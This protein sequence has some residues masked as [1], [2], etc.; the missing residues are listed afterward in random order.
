MLSWVQKARHRSVAGCTKFFKPRVDKL[1]HTLVGEDN[2]GANLWCILGSTAAAWLRCFRVGS[3]DKV[4]EAIP[5]RLQK[6]S[7]LGFSLI[8]SWGLWWM[9]P[10]PWGYEQSAAEFALKMLEV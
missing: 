4:R 8:G 5:P 3:V 9:P 6:K 7:Y 2:H 10:M 1:V